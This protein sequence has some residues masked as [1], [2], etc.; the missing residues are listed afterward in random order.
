MH[1]TT[2]M[3]VS[4]KVERTSMKSAL[5]GTPASEARGK[6]EVREMSQMITTRRLPDAPATTSHRLGRETMNQAHAICSQPT[7]AKKT[8]KG[9][10][11]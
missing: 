9:A 8:P 10:Y 11:S 7:T 4:N 1:E 5:S 2:T 6:P 3:S